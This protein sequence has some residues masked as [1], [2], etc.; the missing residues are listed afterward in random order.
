MDK[1]TD[2]TD[3]W[4]NSQFAGSG[5]NREQLRET[6]MKVIDQLFDDFVENPHRSEHKLSF[7]D[8]GLRTFNADV[9]TNPAKLQATY[10]VAMDAMIIFTEVLRCNE[11]GMLPEK[12]DNDGKSKGYDGATQQLHAEIGNLLNHVL[13][14]FT[15]MF[16][17]CISYVRHRQCTSLSATYPSFPIMSARK[18]DKD[19]HTLLNW[20]YQQLFRAR[21]HQHLGRIFVP[22][23]TRHGHFTKTYTYQCDIKD[24]FKYYL[25]RTRGYDMW[26][27][28]V[29]TS[30]RMKHACT[31]LEETTD[32]SFPVLKRNRNAFAF[33]NC[34]YFCA[35]DR[36]EIYGE[37]HWSPSN[38]T[39]YTNSSTEHQ[40][41]LRLQARELES[42][43]NLEAPD[44]SDRESDDEMIEEDEDEMIGGESIGMSAMNGVRKVTDIL[45]TGIKKRAVAAV[46]F[47]PMEFP[48][49]HMHHDNPLN[50]PTPYWDSIFKTQGF[51]SK[52]NWE[53]LMLWINGMCGRLLYDLSA[54]SDPPGDN[55]QVAPMFK[56]IAGTGKGCILRLL[57]KFYQAADIVSSPPLC[58]RRRRRPLLTPTYSVPQGILSN[59][60]EKKFGM[61]GLSTKL[62]TLCMEMRGNFQMDQADFQSM[63]SNEDMTVARK[64]RLALQTIWNG[65]LAIAGNVVANWSDSGGSIGRRLFPIIFDKIVR[66]VDSTL[67]ANL[68]QELPLVMLK[69][70]RCYITIKKQVEENG[71]DF[72]KSCPKDF[73][74]ARDKLALEIS[75]FQAFLLDDGQCH[76]AQ[77]HGKKQSE[78]YWSW[79]D[80][81]KAY[82]M[83][84]RD[85][86]STSTDLS[87]M[88]EFAGLFQKIG[89]EVV[90]GT[91]YDVLS[92]T[93]KGGKWAMGIR[94]AAEGMPNREEDS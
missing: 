29:E 57:R 87:K 5:L 64:N 54:D 24:F 55:W 60:I 10:D 49:E 79:H 52:P 89:I 70:N 53:E 25:S 74:D 50:I 28:A 58:R 35:E 85:T 76:I 40:D 66:N 19:I 93:E 33:D 7:T 30:N 43:A 67:D 59:N 26:A 42:M 20:A 91:K 45:G 13:T 83:W 9:S 4:K 51:F 17:H 56:G 34:I 88:S 36:V 16:E 37:A 6:C 22:V 31:V 27:K 63:I 78:Y 80:L 1:L 65:S 39:G 48:M 71:N 94:C 84:C 81:K 68:A 62:M 73:V 69:I 44:T 14:G 3:R 72:W 18:S 86:G 46:N 12:A 92:N 90:S 75:S 15:E 21:A 82:S 32:A 38:M 2:L 11:V 77:L 8:Y 47:F 41:E 23:Y 61:E